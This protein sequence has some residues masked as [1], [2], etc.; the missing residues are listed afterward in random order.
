MSFIIVIGII[1][2]AIGSLIT[3]FGSKKDSDKS[4]QIVIDKID[5]F[6]KELN[7]VKNDSSNGLE[8]ASKIDELTNEFD[9]WAV[10]LKENY[11]EIKLSYHKLEVEFS[12][13]ELK[14]NKEWKPFYLEVFKNIEKM[15]VSINKHL[16][17]KDKIV[18]TK[19]SL[20]PQSLFNKTEPTLIWILKFNENNFWKIEL[21]RYN[22]Q[23]DKLNLPDIQILF[24][25]NLDKLNNLENVIAPRNLMRLMIT[26]DSIKCEVKGKFR[27]IDINRF[28]NDPSIENINEILKT[29]LQYQL[30]HINS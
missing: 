19:N 2:I 11:P 12:E 22:M 25:D 26:N 23:N 6:S 27:Y 29:C 17:E 16:N 1:L 8:K 4:Q 18:L 7:K 3:F 28:S 24:E 30:V 15:I 10:N 14:L 21:Y 13:K 5:A 9:T 20:L